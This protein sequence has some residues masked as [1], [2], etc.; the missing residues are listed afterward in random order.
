MSIAIDQSIT[1]QLL[2][3]AE[4]GMGWQLVGIRVSGIGH[5]WST[6]HSSP[7]CSGLHKLS[8][9]QTGGRPAHL[10]LQSPI[11]SPNTYPLLTLHSTPSVE[12]RSP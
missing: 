9:H 8:V 11:L 12:Y 1:A 4:T 10:N 2:I 7:N 6:R 3:Q 5:R